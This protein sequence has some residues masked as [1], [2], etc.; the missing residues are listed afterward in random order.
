MVDNPTGLVEFKVN[1]KFRVDDI[2]YVL[3]SYNVDNA[4]IFTQTIVDGG[5]QFTHTYLYI[6]ISYHHLIDF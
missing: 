6:H 3:E 5:E 1:S 4:Q 2:E